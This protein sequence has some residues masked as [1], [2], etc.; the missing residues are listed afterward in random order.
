MLRWATGEGGGR[1]GGRPRWWRGY[2]HR[3]SRSNSEESQTKLIRTART[4]AGADS[5]EEVGALP[6][7]PS[8]C[9]VATLLSAGS[10]LTAMSRHGLTL[11]RRMTMLGGVSLGATRVPNIVSTDEMDSHFAL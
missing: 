2:R 10:T 6:Q 9:C 3:E 4:L 11:R 1:E 5:A 8:L 7:Y